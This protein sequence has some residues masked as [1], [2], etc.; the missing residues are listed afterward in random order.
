MFSFNQYKLWFLSLLVCSPL[1]QALWECRADLPL[2]HCKSDEGYIFKSTDKNKSNKCARSVFRGSVWWNAG[3]FRTVIW[4]RVSVFKIS[5]AGDW[6]F[7][8]WRCSRLV[9]GPRQ[10]GQNILKDKWESRSFWWEQ[11][12]ARPLHAHFLTALAFNLEG[13]GVLGASRV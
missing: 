1:G 6:I 8:I 4:M 12:G 13:E 10:V 5:K 3:K 9:H 7:K 11:V 2:P